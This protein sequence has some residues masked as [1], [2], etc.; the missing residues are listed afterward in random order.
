MMI[1][2]KF[3]LPLLKNSTKF[4]TSVSFVAISMLMGYRA[5]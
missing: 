4:S 3:T 5:S 1:E 2:G